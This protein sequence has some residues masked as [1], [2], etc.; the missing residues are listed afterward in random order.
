MVVK[1]PIHTRCIV[2]TAVVHAIVNVFLAVDSSVARGTITPVTVDQV[3][4]GSPML[5]GGAGTLVYIFVV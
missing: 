4:T 2:G 5:T 1:K 3:H